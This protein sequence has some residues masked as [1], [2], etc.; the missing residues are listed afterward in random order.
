MSNPLDPENK[1]ALGKNKDYSEV[2]HHWSDL[3]KE[4]PHKY[5]QIPISSL[6]SYQIFAELNDS[7]SLL[8]MAGEKQSYV[9][10]SEDKRSN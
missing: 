4:A 1:M 6:A 8:L 7:V 9:K 2:Q 3:P 5:L 10:K